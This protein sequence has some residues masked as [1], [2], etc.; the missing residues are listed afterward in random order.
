[1]QR[2][3]AGA[4]LVG[5][6]ALA[7]VALAQG[8]R[9]EHAGVGCLLA[10]RFPRIEAH[11]EPA[12]A[13][14]RARVYFR[15]TGTQAWYFV[16]MKAA[17]DLFQGTLPKPKRETKGVDYYVEALDTA[18]RE[19]RTQE[20]RPVVVGN[21]AAC[22][23][24]T[25]AATMASA[26]VVL[27]AAAGAPAVPA[28]FANAGVVAAS[29]SATGAA[30]AASAAGGGLSTGALVGVIGGA[31][32]VAGGVA[33]AAGGGGDGDRGPGDGGSGAGEVFAFTFGTGGPQTSLDVSVCAGRSLVWNSQ[34]ARVLAGGSFD[35]VWSPGEPNTLRVSGRGDASRLDATLRCVSGAGP[36]GSIA[37]TGNGINYSG[38]FSLGSSQGP[39]TVT[40]RSSQP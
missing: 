10:D 35:E 5:A 16:E 17:G 39:V 1:M 38:T 2:Q 32:A 7:P 23:R 30:S 36:T 13:V 3:A 33:V 12:A 15:A 8:P 25:M 29:G 20:F 34:V 18:F 6:L 26:Q 4:L 24:L 14:S 40:R 9:V 21:A 27:G 37:A 11:L 28:G 22:R 19:G 31:A